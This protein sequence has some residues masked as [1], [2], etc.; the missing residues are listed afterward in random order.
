MQEIVLKVKTSFILIY[1]KFYSMTYKF[2]LER[3]LQMM[4]MG[5][6]SFWE[7]LVHL[8]ITIIHIILRSISFFKILFH[9]S[10]YLYIKLVLLLFNSVSWL[11]D[12]YFSIS[13]LTNV[14]LSLSLSH[15]FLIQRY[16]TANYLHF[17]GFPHP[18]PSLPRQFSGTIPFY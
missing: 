3:F 9:F 18:N 16:N 10:F 13:W 1:F 4:V 2:F 12:T 6:E 14:S 17:H 11:T 8:L 15:P 7:L 5:P